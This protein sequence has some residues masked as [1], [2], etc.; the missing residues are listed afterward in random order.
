MQLQSA[1]TL[2]VSSTAIWTQV[3]LA[4]GDVN[5]HSEIETEFATGLVDSGVQKAD[6]AI[7][8][9][10]RG[11]LS[12]AVRYTIMPKLVM[13]VDSELYVDDP[14]ESNYS[15]VNGPWFAYQHGLLELSEAY[16]DFEASSGYWRL[17]KQQVVWGQADGLKVLDVVNPQDY[18]EFN[19]DDFEDSRISLWMLNAE[20]T[21]SDD[22]SL[23]LLLIPDATYSRLADIGTPY[24]ITSA[25]YRPAP[26]ASAFPLVVHEVERPHHE[27]EVGAR[28]RLFYAGWDLTLNYL[29]H[30]QDIPVIYRR[31]SASHLDVE[32][33]YEKNT[34]LGATA[35]NAFGNWVVRAEAGYST[36]TYQLRNSVEN[37]GIANTP[38]FSSV[39]GLDYRGLSDWFI[40]YQWFQSTLT[41]Y[42]DDIIRERRR[43]QHTFLLRRSLLNE[44]LEI[45]LFT[46]YSDEDQDGQ[47][48][49]KMSYLV[50]DEVRI[51]AGVDIF[52]GDADGQFG[53][54][55]DT[56]RLVLGVEFG[57]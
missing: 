7:K 55:N 41:D 18:R 25:K 45:E 29:H 12:D 47:V 54:F 33:V 31:L 46:L 26:G 44:T 19:L 13:A 36:D 10:I 15:S 11:E 22:A 49:S 23:Q 51:W 34:L 9:D 39:I 53:Q 3:A 17:G 52:Y 27:V 43:M 28:Y 2:L 42:E 57:L 37:E 14:D 6:V 1:L 56:D 5:I 8:L 30:R 48:R 32:P 16:V 35:S 4:L 21:I 40:S 24:Y 50:N 20:F 38:E